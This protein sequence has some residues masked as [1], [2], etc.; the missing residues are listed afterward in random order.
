M[1]GLP[2]LHKPVLVGRITKLNLSIFPVEARKP[3]YPE[4]TTFPERR[5]V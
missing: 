4:K 1:A 5:L 2:Q 3:E